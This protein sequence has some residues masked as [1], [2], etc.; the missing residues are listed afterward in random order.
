MAKLSTDSKFLVAQNSSHDIA[1]NE[2][3]LLVEKIREL[4]NRVQE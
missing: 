1:I 4:L 2:P 3:E